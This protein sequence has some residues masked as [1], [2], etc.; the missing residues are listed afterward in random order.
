MPSLSGRASEDEEEENNKGLAE[1]VQLLLS[2]L[3]LLV[4]V[5]RIAFVIVRDGGFV[6]E[7]SVE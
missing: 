7:L 3:F 2:I 6:R 5:R 1:V 4:F